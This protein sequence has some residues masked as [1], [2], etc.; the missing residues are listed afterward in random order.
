MSP[1]AS[2]RRAAG[3]L[4]RRPSAALAFIVTLACGVA[5]V[6]AVLY[7]AYLTLYRPLPFAAEHQLFRVIEVSGA[8]R[9]PS[10]SASLALLRE[11]HQYSATVDKFAAYSFQS[12][13]VEGLGEAH[14]VNVAITSPDFLAL[15]GTPLSL[16]S[17]PDPRNLREAVVAYHYWQD[18]LGGRDDVVG[19]T[20]TLDGAAVRIV[21][22]AGREFQFPDNDIDGWVVLAR[23]GSDRTSVPLIVRLKQG[24]L[25][26]D[27]E[28]E[29]E[30][31]LRL[32]R[33]ASNEVTVRLMPLRQALLGDPVA[34]LTRV[35]VPAA[36]T[37]LIAAINLIVLATLRLRDRQHDDLIRLAIG[38][39]PSALLRLHLIEMGVLGLAALVLAPAVSVIFWGAFQSWFGTAARFTPVDTIQLA[40]ITSALTLLLLV[41][42]T[43]VAVSVFRY[44]LN[45]L[46]QAPLPAGH[47]RPRVH[48]LRHLS[49]AFQ[50]TAS[51]LLVMMTVLVVA[52]YV[53]MTQVD[54]G[55][56]P[57]S[58]LTAEMHVPRWSPG[59]SEELVTSVPR[60]LERN[61][62]V[63][64]AGF[65]LSLPP[66]RNTMQVT[67]HASRAEGTDD[68][69]I[70]A[71]LRFVSPG[72]LRAVGT[73]LL[74]GQYFGEASESGI[75]DVVVNQQFQLAYGLGVGDTVRMSKTLSYRI[76]GLIGDVR[77]AG[78]RDEPEPEIYA[79]NRGMHNLL[80]PGLRVGL[81]VRTSTSPV[82]FAGTLRRTLV[83]LHP[84][85]SAA[86]IETL[87]DRYSRSIAD[88]RLRATALLGLTFASVLVA[89]AGLFAGITQQLAT[90]RHELAVRR[91]L[92][93]SS[94]SLVRTVLGTELAA[95]AA[96]AAVG[97]ALSPI[98]EV[99]LRPYL[100]GMAGFTFETAA[101]TTAVVVGLGALAVI[102]PI[103]RALRAHPLHALRTL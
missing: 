55:L 22:V 83:A 6:S 9:R 88:I 43:L 20:W 31:I 99:L 54:L 53:D 24:Q 51:V 91:A 46:V 28:A 57:E 75:V 84:S 56:E 68:G 64:A 90:R 29:G 69:R 1:L 32:L 5:P 12:S 72:Y 66:T 62:N 36:L 48:R 101:L 15:L 50:A 63:V 41:A 35:A 17:W 76:S 47:S 80:V 65:A 81:A 44:D 45:Q 78:A 7:L 23:L 93:A 59:L 100:F 94:G 8:D 30:R 61:G 10:L 27:A 26:V 42:C 89:C 40:A 86:R 19:R 14:T 52:T 49:L 58:V 103:A 3:T 25:A 87:A 67:L 82:L 95:A 77:T 13:V 97:L 73:T 39:T 18:R 98:C 21:G 2:L 37:L 34:L 33:P 79:D 16:G 92:G 85:L 74:A 11:W 38:A 71:L 102:R 4:Q 70:V 96:G 60:E